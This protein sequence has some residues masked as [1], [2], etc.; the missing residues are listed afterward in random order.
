MYKINKS[1]ISY[2]KKWL[3]APTEDLQF[4]HNHL[5]TL[6][7]YKHLTEDERNTKTKYSIDFYH[8]EIQKLKQLRNEICNLADSYQ[9]D[10]LKYDIRAY[11]FNINFYNAYLKKEI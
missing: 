7:F 2:F 6:F 5:L 1:G 10:T 9:M 11:E 3:L 8:M 4:G